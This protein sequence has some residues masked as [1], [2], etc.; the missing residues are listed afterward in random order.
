MV[1]SA[2]AIEECEIDILDFSVSE[3]LVRLV[4]S[5]CIVLKAESIAVC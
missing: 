4:S 2:E 1:E 5:T 3:R